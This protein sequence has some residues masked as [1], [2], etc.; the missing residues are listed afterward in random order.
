EGLMNMIKHDIEKAK[1]NLQNEPFAYLQDPK[2]LGLRDYQIKAIKNV[3][4]ALDKGQENILLS[5][6]TGTGKTRTTIG[7]IYRK[8]PIAGVSL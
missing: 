4:V 3:E 5:M 7:L 6:A 2:G 8:C 1:E